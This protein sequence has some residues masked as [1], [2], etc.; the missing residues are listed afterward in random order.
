MLTSAKIGKQ[1]GDTRKPGYINLSNVFHI[2]RIVPKYSVCFLKHCNCDVKDIQLL[3]KYK[4]N[5]RIKISNRRA[6]QRCNV[7][8]FFYA[9]ICSLLARRR[10]SQ[11][12][13]RVY[14]PENVIDWLG[15]WRPTCIMRHAWGQKLQSFRRK[16]PFYMDLY[17]M[18]ELRCFDVSVLTLPQSFIRTRYARPRLIWGFIAFPLAPR[19]HYSH[20]DLYSKLKRRGTRQVSVI[21]STFTA[22]DRTI[23]FLTTIGRTTVREG[24]FP[25]GGI[26]SYLAISRVELIRKDKEK[27]RSARKIPPSEKRSLR[28]KW[29]T[30]VDVVFYQWNDWTW[31]A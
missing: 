6:T 20:T 26:F 7:S 8:A 24:R 5:H 15:K 9:K 28:L 31:L 4:Q 25:L 17:S 10:S 12:V 21:V 27:F 14:W 18:A 30:G 13:Q 11:P 16:W 19:A 22:T 29:K 2:Y 3:E 1:N 23:C